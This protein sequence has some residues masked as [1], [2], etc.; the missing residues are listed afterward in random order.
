MYVCLVKNIQEIS[1]TPGHT[2][3]TR[4]LYPRD[5]KM[6]HA[7]GKTKFYF[8]ASILGPIL[9]AYSFGWMLERDQGMNGSL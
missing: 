5:I 6:G 4:F 9:N 2:I 3:S 7:K 8:F 1:T